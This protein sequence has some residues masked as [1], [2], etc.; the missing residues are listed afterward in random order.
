M[1]LP[2]WMLARTGPDDWQ[3]PLHAGHGGARPRSGAGHL[4]RRSLAAFAGVLTAML[5]QDETAQRRGV[6]QG[7]DARSKLLGLGVLLVTATLLHH[8]APLAL[9]LGGTLLLLAA[10]RVPAALLLRLWL[11][12]PLFSLAILLPATLNLVTPGAPVAVLWHAADGR[13]LVAVTGAGLVVAGRL[14]LRLLACVTLVLLLTATTPRP[15]LW[16]GLRGL[17]VPA[18]VVM[19]LSLMERYLVVLVR[20]AEELHLAKLSRSL[21][22]TS[23]A[24]EQV[25][26][27]AGMGELYRRSR[28]LSEQVYLAMIARGYR[29]A[30]HLLAPPHWRHRDWLALALALGAATALLL[31]DR[32]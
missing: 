25:W 7:L 28:A 15:Q 20:I 11:A 30:A 14:L 26:M 21:A 23:V 18:L 32:R 29:G 22:A 1:N 6:L 16:R 31:G 4:A 24:R 27:A 13:P 2:P 19:L 5:Q 17:G 10:S 12:A 3:Q 8:A 9:L